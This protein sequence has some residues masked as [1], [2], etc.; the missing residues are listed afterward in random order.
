MSNSYVTALKLYRL[1]IDAM[2]ENVFSVM[3]KVSTSNLTDE[4]KKERYIALGKNLINLEAIKY[5]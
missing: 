1:K 4:Q 3:D 2:I 5:E